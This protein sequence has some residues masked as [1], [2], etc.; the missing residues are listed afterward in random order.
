VIR[1]SDLERRGGYRSVR[2]RLLMLAEQERVA[3]CGLP[4]V[5]ED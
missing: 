3:V 1:Q 5:V 2:Q 4:V